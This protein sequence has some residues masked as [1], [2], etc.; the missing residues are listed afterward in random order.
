MSEVGLYDIKTN[1]KIGVAK[2]VEAL[3]P[4]ATVFGDELD[5][6][7]VREA[8]KRQKALRGKTMELVKEMDGKSADVLESLPWML[9]AKERRQPLLLRSRQSEALPQAPELS[10]EEAAQLAAIAERHQQAEAVQSAYTLPEFFASEL[11]KYAYL[12]DISVINGTPLKPEDAEFMTRYEASEE[13]RTTTG[14]RFEQLRSL[15]PS[16]ERIA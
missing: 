13:Y 10:E 5:M 7:K 6:Q 9:P 11:D 14:R 1:R 4:L 2:P 16:K 15:Y 12:F 3:N 8:N